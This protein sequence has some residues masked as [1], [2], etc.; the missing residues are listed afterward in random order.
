MLLQVLKL[1]LFALAENDL[2][3]CHANEMSKNVLN[4]RMASVPYI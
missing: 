2:S 4:K 1:N 3:L